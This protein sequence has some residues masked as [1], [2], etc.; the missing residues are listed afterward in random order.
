MIEFIFKMPFYYSFNAE[1]QY[2]ICFEAINPFQKLYQPMTNTPILLKALTIVYKKILFQ[3]FVQKHRNNY[4][5]QLFFSQIKYIHSKQPE[6][7]KT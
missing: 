6:I 1:F 3:I 4:I 7:Q 5:E 2:Y